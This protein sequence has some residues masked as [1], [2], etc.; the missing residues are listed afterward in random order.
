MPPFHCQ[1]SV[2][3]GE[4]AN[5]YQQ[6]QAAGPNA[7][8]PPSMPNMQQPNTIPFRPTGRKRALLV[9]C[10]YKGSSF[11]LNGCINDALC[12]RHLLKTRF[13]FQDA[14]IMLLTDDQSDPQKWPTR[15]NMIY[16]MQMLVW[17]LRPGDSLFFHFS[18]HGSQ[19]VDRSGDEVDG[20]SET[21]CPCDFKLGGMIVD[22][23]LNILLVNPL[24]PGV[25]L[26][27]VID[28]CHSG[29]VMDLEFRAKYKTSRGAYWK[30]EYAWRPSVYKGTR[31]GEAFQFGA[32]RD[33][34]TAAD[35]RR[36]SGSVSTGAA[37][38][39]FI[40]AIER[41]GTGIS[42]LGLLQG[43]YY[44]IASLHGGPAPP[45][46]GFMGKLVDGAMDIAGMSGQSPCL[47]SNVPFDL[48]RPIAI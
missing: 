13:G 39:S 28:A 36:L 21:I 15:A 22:D 12:V 33:S 20:K 42:Y 35:T 29:S 8:V 32:S 31:G 14:D 34:Q 7:E 30:Q 27:V 48:N 6:S 4:R 38:F 26:H 24:P 46:G 19:V 41:N 45:M 9:G 43:M 47:C 40:Q 17:D 44:T 37:T 5:P 16:Q 18:G 3:K 23:E 2:D 1:A 10:N 11:A 25:R